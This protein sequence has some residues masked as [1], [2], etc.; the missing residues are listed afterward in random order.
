[1]NNLIIDGLKINVEKTWSY[2]AVTDENYCG[3]P[4]SFSPVGMGDT[5]QEAIQDYID[6]VKYD[7]CCFC[8]EP[9]FESDNYR[10]NRSSDYFWHTDCTS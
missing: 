8:K 7:D 5:E 6:K 2:W 10:S 1:M 9:I 3:A 4:D